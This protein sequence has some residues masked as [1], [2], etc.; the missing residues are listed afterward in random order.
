MWSRLNFNLD[1]IILTC[2]TDLADFLLT[3]HHAV[4]LTYYV[5]E[6]EFEPRFDDE[7]VTSNW[8]WAELQVTFSV[9]CN[10]FKYL[11]LPGTF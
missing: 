7:N 3:N 10:C 2:D 11:W 6:A 4:K 9:N 8:L 1:L 5:N